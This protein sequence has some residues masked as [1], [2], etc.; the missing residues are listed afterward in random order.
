[1]QW[2]KIVGQDTML[3][4]LL[5]HAGLF[6]NIEN[7]PPLMEEETPIGDHTN[8]GP[9]DAAAP[10]YELVETTIGEH[11]NPGTRELEAPPYYEFS[12]HSDSWS[13]LTEKGCGTR[14][15]KKISISYA[16]PSSTLIAIA[17]SS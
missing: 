5:M 14:L 13:K 11:A 4:W 8:P 1:M 12:C 15:T 10:P 17:C 16:Y 9:H 7:P 3:V 2:L 6:A